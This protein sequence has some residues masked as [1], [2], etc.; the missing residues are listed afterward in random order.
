MI[1]TRRRR[2][3]RIVLTVVK[4]WFNFEILAD[5]FISLARLFHLFI[6][7]YLFIDNTGKVN[8]I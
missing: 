7:I 8:Y 2:A 1:I 3:Q 6:Y 5:S 4:K